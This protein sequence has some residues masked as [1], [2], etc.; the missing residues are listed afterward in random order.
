MDN[1]PNINVTPLIDVLLVLLIIFMV[2]SPI[3]PTDF[4]TKI[5]QE[6]T[7]D[8]AESNIDMLV[9]AINS[10]STLRLNIESDMGTVREPV[11]LIE[12]LQTV[13]RE[14][15]KNRAYADDREFR[16]DLPET[17]RIEKTVFIKAPRSIDYGSVVKVIDAVKIAGA[18]PISLQIDD[19]N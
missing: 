2:V 13:F 10:N 6:P 4:K 5:P 16:N 17:E 18:N 19:L 7:Q 14:R 12:K 3:K 15:T 8:G 11:K 9:V 1:K